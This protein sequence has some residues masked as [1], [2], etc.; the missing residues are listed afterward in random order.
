LT[1]FPTTD[2]KSE[3]LKFLAQRSSSRQETL[4]GLVWATLNSREFAY[5]H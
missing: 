2:E 4:A 3:L 1:R 5:N